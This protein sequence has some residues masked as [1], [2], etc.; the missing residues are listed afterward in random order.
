MDKYN[1]RVIHYRDMY[2]EFLWKEPMIFKRL[3]A[4]GNSLVEDSV[5]YIVKRVAIAD[6]IQHVNIERAQS[7]DV[8]S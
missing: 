5:E 8:V 1:V 4:V 2:G 7:G 6:D 3:F